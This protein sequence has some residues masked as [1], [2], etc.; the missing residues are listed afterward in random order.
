MLGVTLQLGRHP[1]QGGV[2]ILLH[3]ADHGPQRDKPLNSN[4]DFTI[5]FRTYANYS[6]MT[7]SKQKKMGLRLL[8]FELCFNNVYMMCS[9]LFW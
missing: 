5:F 4:A 7:I 9:F 6:L 1:I 3:E 2:E 8:S